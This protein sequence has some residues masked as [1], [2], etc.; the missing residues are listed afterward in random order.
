[1]LCIFLYSISFMCFA[2]AVWARCG[3]RMC[4]LQCIMTVFGILDLDTSG[5]LTDRSF[6]QDGASVCG[7]PSANVAYVVFIDYHC[8]CQLSAGVWA[9][10]TPKSLILFWK[11]LAFNSVWEVGFYWFYCFYLCLLIGDLRCPTML[12]LK[13]FI[14]KA[15]SDWM[16][17]HTNLMIGLLV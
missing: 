9:A 12:F 5:R 14:N 6:T 8:K 11:S 16:M 1:M 7:L 10:N 4:V 13:C 17:F 2:I 15:G 3:S